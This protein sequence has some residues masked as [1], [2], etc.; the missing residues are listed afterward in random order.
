VHIF[1]TEK[2]HSKPEKSGTGAN[3]LLKMMDKIIFKND[4]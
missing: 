1:L 3:D 4:G 2:R